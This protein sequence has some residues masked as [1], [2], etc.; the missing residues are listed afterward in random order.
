MQTQYQNAG[1][2]VR[3]ERR[4]GYEEVGGQVR[5]ERR[6]EYYSA[7]NQERPARR[8]Y[9]ERTRAKKQEKKSNKNTIRLV[10]CALILLSAISAKIICPEK[11]A[12]Y[13]ETILPMMEEDFDYKAVAQTIGETIT[14]EQ[15][16]T[17][18]L[19]EIYVKAFGGGGEDDIKVSEQTPQVQQAFV[20]TPIQ[21]LHEAASRIAAERAVNSEADESEATPSP[22]TQEVD[23]DRTAETTNTVVEAFLL[24]QAAFSDYEL[25]ANVS[26]DMPEMGITYT[27]PI[28]GRVSSTFGYRDHPVDGTV[29]FHYGTDVA[30]NTG[31]PIG[32]FADGTVTAVADSTVSGLNVTITHANG[33]TTRYVH[34]S[35]IYVN[36]GDTVKAGDI[37]AAAGDTGNT[38]GPH[39]HLE[40]CVNGMYVNP[41]YYLNFSYT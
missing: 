11:V 21:Q 8:E 22:S 34:C 20:L 29:I 27:C 1:A 18:V 36:E 19:G 28:V 4:R 13:A 23:N 9:P 41:E 17:Q 31:D 2:Q 37:I 16:I 35:A 39:L 30:A 33:I 40:L 3:A 14:G 32:A 10:I 26:Y 6:R 38:T 25:P 7:G 24:N 15:S 5:S 12:E